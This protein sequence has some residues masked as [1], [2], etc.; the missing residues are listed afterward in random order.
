MQR[1]RQSLP[2]FVKTTP[3]I[4]GMLLL[5]ACGTSPAAQA[6]ISDLDANDTSDEQPEHDVPSIE[7]DAVTDA[8]EGVDDT[9]D[10]T[11]PPDD[12]AH[13]SDA[14]VD[15][16]VDTGEPDPCD[17]LAM[18]C[19]GIEGAVSP[20]SP[21][22][23]TYGEAWPACR[24]VPRDG[25]AFE[26]RYWI[27]W[28]A[29]GI[30][31]VQSR[32]ED[33]RW[34][35]S[36]H[37]FSSIHRSLS[38]G[39]YDVYANRHGDGMGVPPAACT[40][41][42]RVVVSPPSGGFWAHLRARDDTPLGTPRHLGGAYDAELWISRSPP[43]CSA[44]TQRIANSYRENVTYDWGVRGDPTD[45]P[46]L[47]RRTPRSDS[48]Q[49]QAADGLFVADAPHPSETWTLSVATRG[50]WSDLR[51]TVGWA[52]RTLH[53]AVIDG[54]SP[55]EWLVVGSVSFDGEAAFHEVL[56]SGVRPQG[57]GSLL[58]DPP[59]CAT[60]GP[61]PAEI[62]DG[63]DNDCDGLIDEAPEACMGQPIQPSNCAYVQSAD[64]WICL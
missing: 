10:G 17:A 55:I 6:P 26:G 60:E 35:G 30:E 57:C 56:A 29:D 59:D 24:F 19:D 9:F 61:F 5:A 42:P 32:A 20:T 2:H 43:L 8:D 51:L 48:Q 54:T 13:D 14:E 64:F 18:E 34:D 31:I 33:G 11:P 47:M 28:L 25:S 3:Y 46:R 41:L 21:L 7:G 50:T 15:V 1:E 53:E 45:D 12:T 38:P 37:G 22:H 52:G 40:S 44:D 63:V 62:C 23:V 58:T 49:I 16:E 27:S 39:T 4:A 36:V